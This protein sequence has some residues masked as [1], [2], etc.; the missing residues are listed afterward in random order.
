VEPVEHP[1]TAAVR[2]VRRFGKSMATQVL[3]LAAG[4]H[5]VDVDTEVDWHESEAFLKAAFPLDVRADRSASET[6]FGFVERPTV[7]NTS[8]DAA[9]FE[10]CA[11]RY[12][13]VGEPGWGA[14]VVNDST[15]GHDVPR[16]AHVKLMTAP[17]PDGLMDGATHLGGRALG[18]NANTKY[19]NQAWEFIKYLESSKTLKTYLQFPAN[20]KTSSARS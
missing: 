15:Y 9:K 14:A 12:V 16:T 20:K 8:W 7:P 19:P 4:A 5:R 13:H 11:H 6:Q 3:S 10:I 2:V 17:M 1:G 18:I